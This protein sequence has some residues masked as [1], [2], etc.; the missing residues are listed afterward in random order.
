MYEVTAT[1]AV[2]AG[3]SAARICNLHCGSRRHRRCRTFVNPLSTAEA[4][5]ARPR[6]VAAAPV[7]ARPTAACSTAALLH[8]LLALGLPVGC[9]VPV[10]KGCPYMLRAG[11]NPGHVLTLPLY[12]PAQTRTR[13]SRLGGGSGDVTWALRRAPCCRL[14]SAT[15]SANVL[16]NALPHAL[17][18]CT[19]L[20]CDGPSRWRSCRSSPGHAIWMSPPRHQLVSFD[21]KHLTSRQQRLRC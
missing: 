5:A 4:V 10:A 1:R 12:A 21:S 7:A 15:R 16:C 14:C 20:R 9:V 17:P 13:D 8:A 11:L 19:L 6:S 3:A 18:L 2:A